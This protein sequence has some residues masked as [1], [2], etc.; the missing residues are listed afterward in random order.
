MLGLSSI[1][2][3]FRNEFKNNFNST[4][5]WISDFIYDIKSILIS[6]FFGVKMLQFCH[7]FFI[8]A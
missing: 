7:L 5:V 4:L 6:Q 2:Y 3:F 1:L 8:M